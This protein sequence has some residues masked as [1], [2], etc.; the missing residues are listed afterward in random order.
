MVVSNRNL[1]FQGSM[2]VLGGVSTTR[3]ARETLAKLGDICK[4][5]ETQ[6]SGPRISC[7]SGPTLPKTKSSP[8][9][10]N[11]WK[12]EYANFLLGLPYL[13]RLC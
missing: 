7:K 8:V 10:I 9:K 12:L 6:S 4:N 2:F 1:L 3:I 11:G 5:G 13:Q